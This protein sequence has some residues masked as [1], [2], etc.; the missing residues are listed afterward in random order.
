MTARGAGLQANP[1]EAVRLFQAAADRGSAAAMRNLGI[2]YETG[3]GVRADRRRAI[4]YYR[5]AAE[6][7]DDSARSELERLGVS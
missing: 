3:Q 6:A 1:A 4:D 2:M 5:K 7:G